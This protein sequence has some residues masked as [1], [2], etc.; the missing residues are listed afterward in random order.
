MRD[1]LG[2]VTHLLLAVVPADQDSTVQLYAA[3][4][5]DINLQNAPAQVK[6]W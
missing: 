2:I 6:L 5:S 1:P 4:A 3:D